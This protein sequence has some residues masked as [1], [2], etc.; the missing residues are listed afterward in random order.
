MESVNN[1][2]NQFLSSLFVT[3]QLLPQTTVHTQISSLIQQSNSD[4]SKTFTRLLLLIRATNHGNAIITTHGTNFEYIFTLLY[5]DYDCAA[6]T[7]AITYD[8]NCSCGLN[9]NCTTQA[10]FVNTQSSEILP[11][12]GL[13]IGCTPSESFL[14]STLECFYNT[15]CVNLIQEQMNNDDGINDVDAPI[16]LAMNDSRFP[17]NTTILNL[18]QELFTEEWSTTINYSAYFDQCSP[19]S[20]SYTYIQQVNPFYTV[21]VLLGLYGGLTFILKW[22]CSNIIYV[23]AKVYWWRKKRRNSIQPV[24][25]I[26]IAT[27]DVVSTT[28]NSINGSDITVDPESMPRVETPPYTT[29]SFNVSHSLS[30]SF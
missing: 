2:V 12:N 20:C 10:N 17:M 22:I 18:V 23:M 28:V 19:T 16:L 9:A 21:T 11:I 26:E 7:Q 6:M 13:K 29:L 25:N 27:I 1:S 24:S 30:L 5:D 3:A 4:V 14:S 8:Y 15:S